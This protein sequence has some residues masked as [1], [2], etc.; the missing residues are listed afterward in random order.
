[1]NPVFYLCTHKYKFT[2]KSDA[3]ISK[4]NTYKTIELNNRLPFIQN[5]LTNTI[6]SSN[7]R[8]LNGNMHCKLALRNCLN[9]TLAEYNLC[10][11]RLEKG[12]R[13]V[14]AAQCCQHQFTVSPF[15]IILFAVSRVHVQ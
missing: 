6:N 14:S 1:M 10:T 11:A 2:V 5:K 12:I 3:S 4:Y 15:V 9:L 7:K 13:L 8:S